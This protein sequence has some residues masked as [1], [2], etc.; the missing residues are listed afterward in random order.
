MC[1]LRNLPTDAATYP[2]VN[3]ANADSS[4]TIQI[5]NET[6]AIARQ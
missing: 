4:G 5:N 2:D 3:F 1:Y 6:K